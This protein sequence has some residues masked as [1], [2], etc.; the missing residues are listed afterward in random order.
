[1]ASS[2]F[3]DGMIE[4]PSTDSIPPELIQTGGTTSLYEINKYDNYI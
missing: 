4:C 3:L 1:M 2:N